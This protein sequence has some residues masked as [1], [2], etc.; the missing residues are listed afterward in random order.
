M[1]STLTVVRPANFLL[2]LRNEKFVTPSTRVY[3]THTQILR[4]METSV[5]KL[6]EKITKKSALKF[7]A[8]SSSYGNLGLFVG[9]GF[10]KAVLNDASDGVALSWSELLER[11]AQKMGVDYA[12]IKKIGVSYPEIASAISTAHAKAKGTTF[13]ESLTQLKQGIAELTCLYPSQQQREQYSTYLSAI[14]PSWIITTNYDLVI[15]SLLTGKSVPLGPNDPL[16]SPKGVVPVFHLHGIRTN[17]EEIII[18]QEDYVTLFRPS[19]YRQVKLALTIRESTT[20]FLGYGLGDVN[21]L[22][23]L[24]WSR[25]VFKGEEPNYPN[26]VVQVLRKQNPSATPYRDRNGILIIETADLSDFLRDLVDSRNALAEKEQKEQTAL[27]DLA[28]RLNSPDASIISNFIDDPQFR[29]GILK[30]LSKFSIHLVAGFVS[31]LDKCIDETWERSRPSGHFEGYNQNLTIILDILTTFS[32]DRFPPA[33]FQA[34]A[35]GLDRVAYY[36]GNEGGKSWSA[37]KTWEQ[38]RETLSP[39]ITKELRSVAEQYSYM[40]L[41]ELLGTIHSS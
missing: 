30:I 27:T 39:E 12:K 29:S 26:D 1:A 21:V 17:P 35:F 19:E 37:Q 36:V 15:E 18:S 31:F 33:L 34:A 25:N 7:L 4:T 11:T 5:P 2:N 38:R 23:A 32:L 16:S 3:E 28:S 9:A 8:Q 40:R 6:D 13:S 20:L 22:T 24:D 14:S 41:E 10:S